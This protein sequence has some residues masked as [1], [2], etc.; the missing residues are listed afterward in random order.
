MD[1]CLHVKLMRLEM[2]PKRAVFLFY[3]VQYSTTDF[4][5]RPAKK[6]SQ[7]Y[8]VYIEY[9]I[10]NTIVSEPTDRVK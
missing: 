6:E 7:K 5:I 4:I 3:L 2:F 9:Y 1:I 8:E 10:S